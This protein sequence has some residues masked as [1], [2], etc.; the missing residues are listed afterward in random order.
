MIP[1]ALSPLDT[2]DLAAVLLIVVAWIVSGRLVEHPPKSRLSVSVLM[3]EYRRD[4][5][6]HFV[7]RQPRMF[8]GVL[9]NSLRQATAFLVSTSMI[10]IGGCV[11]MIRNAPQLE[12]LTHNVALLQG[13]QMVEVKLVLTVSFLANAL[14]KFI[15]SHRLFG[16]CEI[17]MASVPNDITDPLAYHRAGQAGEVNVQAAKQFNRGL[18]SI[19]FALGSLG[20]ILG[21]WALMIT[22]LLTT[23]TL[24]RREFASVSRRVILDKP[25]V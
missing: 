10:A 21:P 25:K 3:Q 5:M 13:T 2:P 9:I 22:T 16:Y 20:W 11:A 6:R 24:L 18:R 14:L 15:W 1:S 12:D 7:T 23:M 8:D 17:L 19:Y 4:W